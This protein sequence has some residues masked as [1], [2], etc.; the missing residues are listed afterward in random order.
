[1]K[2]IKLIGLAVLVVLV[3]LQFI[4][5]RSNQSAEVPSTDF[6]LTYKVSGEVERILHTS[7]Y[8]CHSNNTNYPW[9]SYVQ[10]V[11]LLLEHHINKGKAELNF[12]E[13]GTYSLRKQKSKLKSMANQIE[14]DEMPLSSYTLIHRDARLSKDSKKVLVDYFNALQDSLQQNH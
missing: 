11:G 3:G 1:M 7:C 12:S 6:V 9:Y 14:K 4:P 5:T 8:N 13:F 2:L 10:P